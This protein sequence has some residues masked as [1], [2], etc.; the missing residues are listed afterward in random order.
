MGASK[1]GTRAFGGG[2]MSSKRKGP[3]SLT[4][5]G[6]KVSEAAAGIS[7]AGLGGSLAGGSTRVEKKIG[8]KR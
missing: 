3:E 5:G 4:G 2:A 1:S 8:K 6:S 7:G